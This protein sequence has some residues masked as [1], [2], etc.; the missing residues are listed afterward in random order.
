[1]DSNENPVNANLLGDNKM[2]VD[3]EGTFRGK[4]IDHGVS[5]TKNGFPQWSAK[6]VAEEIWDAD[7]GVWVNWTD[8]QENELTAYFVMFGKNGET[9]NVKQIKAATGWDGLSFRSLNELDL[10]D[11]VVQMR[12]ANHTYEGVT[13]LQADWVD[14]ADAVPGT[15]VRKLDDTEL[16]KIDAAFAAMLKRTAPAKAPAQAPAKAPAPVQAPAKVPAQASAEAPATNKPKKRGR[17]PKDS[18]AISELPSVPDVPATTTVSQGSCTKQEAWVA[19]CEA[20]SA[21][22]TDSKLAEM[23]LE[24]VREVSISSGRELGEFTNEDWYDVKEM[25]ITTLA[26]KF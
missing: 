12:V 4:V 22:V 21:D 24:S 26:M 11:T 5:L 16:A 23:W 14:A 13:K 18:A 25:A 15:G 7:E 17:K 1:M 10:S 19:V 3:R 6:F 2:L 20:R 8:M 9:L